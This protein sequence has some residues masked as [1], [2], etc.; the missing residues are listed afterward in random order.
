MEALYRPY[1][2]KHPSSMEH[3]KNL[4][5]T[6]ALTAYLTQTRTLAS[7]M[8]HAWDLPS[9]LI[10]PVQRL[11]KY[12]LLLRA[13]IDE[14]PDSH[15][16][17]QR[18][19][20]ALK[21][22]KKVAEEVNEGRRRREV[23]REV[24]AGAIIPALN[25][26]NGPEGKPKKKG[27][28]T[29]GLAASVSLGR[30]KSIR[31]L[32]SKGKEGGEGYARGERVRALG[33]RLTMFGDFVQRF[34]VEAVA[35]GKCAQTLI[36]ALDDWAQAFGQV[37]WMGDD[38]R[39]EAFDAF[40]DLIA[41]Q[42]LPVSEILREDINDKVIPLLQS[43]LDA[44]DAPM[45]LLEAMDTLEP[46]HLSLLHGP[47][48]KTRP[49]TGTQLL[50]ASQSY[51]ALCEQLDA[52]LPSCISLCERGAALVVAR[53]A[54][55]QTEFFQRLRDRWADL[56]D[57][58]R[59]D[60]EANQGAEETL[61]VWWGRFAE[62][63]THLGALRIARPP[64]K[65]V[66]P[67]KKAPPEKLRLRPTGKGRPST[68][69]PEGGGGEAAGAA[70]V[71]TMLAALQP[72]N[73]PQPQPSPVQAAFVTSPGPPSGKSRSVHSLESG[74]GRAMVSERKSQESLHSKKSGKSGKSSRRASSRG[75]S[76]GAAP[77]EE[78]PQYPGVPTL[79][80]LSPTPATRDRE[81]D[82][83]RERERAGRCGP[84]LYSCV[85]MGG[86]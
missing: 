3:L 82:R 22:V 73:I 28:L 41:K 45:R 36:L 77:V 78:L 25:I 42:L 34:A 64:E 27:A 4:P 59:V 20:S 5:S 46:L 57:A 14:T 1:I 19:E 53:F 71:S 61:R 81:R 15:P 23:V 17:K 18:L 12:P 69:T 75:N 49:G 26:P 24:L 29:V 84:T 37:I 54:T 21:L 65:K 51:V 33:S 62:V 72:L 35:W 63:E 38:Q 60:E 10:K 16:D 70:V 2:T 56:W 80:A 44:A 85:K 67:E 8:S 31:N 86:R 43:L 7:N 32:T 58:L 55:L 83:E 79:A 52:E 9:L 48:A 76:M 39:S 47:F 30:M 50:D 66:P 68:G 11:L 6:P 40:L 74:E 13:I